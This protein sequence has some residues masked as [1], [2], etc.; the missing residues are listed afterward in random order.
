MSNIGEESSLSYYG[1]IVVATAFLA[2]MMAYGITYSFSVFLK[3]LYSDFGWTRA[4][5]AGAF[6]AYAI[7]HNLFSPFSGWLTDRFGPRVVV[8]TGGVCMAGSMIMMSSIS[9]L[10]EFYIY[11]VILLGWGVAAAYTPVIA[12]VSR[13]FIVNRG[14]AISV[15]AAGMGAGSFLLSPLAAWLITSYG[16]RIAYFV[17]GSM[18]F[19]AFIPVVIFIKKSPLKIYEATRKE[20]LNTMDSISDFSF[21]DALKTRSL[22]ALS[23]SWLFAALALYAI[24]IHIV[25]LITDKE[26]PLTTAGF[27]AGLIGGGSI[28]GKI[29]A[30]FLSDRLGRKKILIVSYVFQTVMLVWLL[31]S[32]ELWMFFV[33]APLFGISFGGWAGVIPAFPAD[34]FGLK[35]TGSIFGFVLIMAG[36]GVAGGSFLGGYIFDVTHSYYYMIVMCI[37]GTLLAICSALLMRNPREV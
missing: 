31:F 16:W 18:V 3:S 15:A 24:M 17:V 37:L 22:W 2:T 32:Q 19:A 34:Y 21:I 1:W 13:W 29:S 25:S 26:I 14:L 36:T 27:L 4:A 9:T 35:A 23:F 10:W 28:I 7:S 6:S 8:A 12:T 30:G 33:F 11:Y 5:T 20:S